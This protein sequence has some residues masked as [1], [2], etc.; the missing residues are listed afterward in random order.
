[1]IAGV[2]LLALPSA[3]QIVIGDNL[4][5]NANGTLSA[6][7]SGTYG[8]QIASTHGVG[9][10]GTLG[11]SGF[12]YN[13]NFVSFNI[14]PYYNQSRS[15]SN[16]GSITD[17]SGVTLSSAI[18][19]GSH[20]PGSVNYS[21]NYNSTGNYGIPGI[22]SLNTNGDSNSF[23]VSWSALLPEWPTL[24]VGYQMGGSNYSLYGTNENGDSSF[25][26]LFLNS[27]YSIAGFGLG[28]GISHGSSNA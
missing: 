7:Y 21:S 15:N 10:G 16:F 20:F 5:L 9:L 11:L 12:F 23:G 17:A 3:G 19:A 14:N 2:L 6:N 18:F 25:R 26:S 1:M 24:T 27:S 8:N 13:P 22:T 28:G 4:N